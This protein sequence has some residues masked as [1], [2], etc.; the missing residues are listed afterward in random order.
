MFIKLSD[1]SLTWISVLSKAEL[2]LML[3]LSFLARPESNMV[4]LER[5]TNSKIREFV[6]VGQGSLDNLYSKLKK[7][8]LIRKY[9]NVIYIPFEFA[10]KSKKTSYYHNYTELENPDSPWLQM[11]SDNFDKIPIYPKNDK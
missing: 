8:K 4:I 2:K 9:G 6:G 11:P 10:N 7:Y 5:G 3:Y 1:K